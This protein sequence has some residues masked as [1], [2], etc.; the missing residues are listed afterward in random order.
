M[1]KLLFIVFS[2]F[3]TLLHSQDI[4]VKVNKGSATLDNEV[5]SSTKGVRKLSSKSKLT[6]G[7]NSLIIVR[8]NKKLIQ[9]KEPKTYKSSQIIQLL[10][11]QK[12]LSSSSYASVLFTEKMQKTSPS[13]QSGSVTRGVSDVNW[14][15][16]DFVPLSGRSLLSDT[17]RI[18]VFNTGITLS[19]S[20]TLLNQETQSSMR[21]E[22]HKE[23][24]YALVSGLPSG[25]YT[26]KLNVFVSDDKAQDKTHELENVINIP[27]AEE[28]LRMKS[29]EKEF[30]QIIS[31]YDPEIRQV[32]LDEFYSE[33][34]WCP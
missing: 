31:S 29:E 28:R 26:W 5:L 24:S 17:F 8:Q 18:E 1:N 16:L 2:L 23:G 9:L 10:S 34:G 4:Y 19:D 7:A 33:K 13:I 21:F 22:L 30:I 20:V 25:E 15:D 27:S 6:V 14:E 3:L 11:N 32:L 12:G